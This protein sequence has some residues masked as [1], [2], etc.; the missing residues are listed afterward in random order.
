M[1]RPRR[2][3]CEA[4][5]SWKLIEKAQRVLADEINLT[6]PAAG[7]DLRMVLCYPN[8]YFV[9]MSNL[10]FQA[11][12]GLLNREPGV[13][14]ERC[15]TPDPDDLSA[16]RAAG[17]SLFS[18][19]S[20]RPLQDFDIVGFSVS[21]ELD[22]VNVLRMLDLS[23]IPLRSADRDSSW[24]LVIMGGAVSF[25]NPEP[26]ADFM[27]AIVVGEGEEAVRAIVAR[28]REGG[29]GD[30][31]ALLRSLAELPG[32]YVP[33]LYRYTYSGLEI[34]GRH[35]VAPAAEHV[36]R[37]A[38]EHL[39]FATHTSVITP[40]TE[41][42]RSFLVEVSRGCPY[43]CRFCV[44]G[45]VYTPNRWRDLEL[46]WETCQ[47]GLQHT[48]RVGMLGAVVNL[49]PKM[50]E[51]TRRL[52]AR[53]AHCSFASLR[54]DSLK[55]E[56]VDAIQAS[57]Q[58]TLT[59][60]PETGDPDLRWFINK[61]MKDEKLFQALEKGVARGVKNFRLYFMMGIPGESDKNVSDTIRI[62]ADAHR[63]IRERAT[64]GATLSASVSQFVPK[65]G[66]P[67]QWMPLARAEEV[68][69][70]MKRVAAHFK[71]APALKLNMESPKWC[72]IQGLLARG[73]RRMAGVLERVRWTTSAA[74]WRAAMEA[75]GMDVDAFLYAE[76]NPHAIM[77][78]DV[79]QTADL[80][81]RMLAELEKALLY[82]DKTAAVAASA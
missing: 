74:P 14:C 78:W 60:A 80:R 47:M 17:S 70:H 9:G 36:K 39:D 56:V 22:F 44:V 7:G 33:S 68:E 28:W 54:A 43:L 71:G 37:L 1:V 61:K 16:H 64:P 65:A 27:D 81:D 41:F 42:S 73:D 75:E 46:L 63:V 72:K 24:P 66:T 6:P 62:I 57:G 30:R 31:D 29:R 49:Y 34:T 55:D 51:L 5:M 19:D 4:F 2:L 38:V 48:N 50:P 76:R 58:S 23:G 25:L 82:R 69:A 11:L 8:T 13:V 15:F 12:Y 35:C 52:L 3:K 20:Q 18:L 32:V 59:L 77:P 79:V 67:F 53:G 10:G 45:Y 21:Y 26:L 40:H